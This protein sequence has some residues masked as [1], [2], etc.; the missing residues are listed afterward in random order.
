MSEEEKKQIDNAIPPQEETE[1]E[2]VSLDD[3]EDFDQVDDED[4]DETENEEELD[5]TQNGL[6]SEETDDLESDGLTDEEISSKYEAEVSNIAP[7][8]EP[9]K[10]TNDIE[11]DPNTPQAIAD[12]PEVDNS[13]SRIAASNSGNI[14]IIVVGILFVLGI[15]YNSYKGHK[16]ETAPSDPA[17]IS[18]QENTITPPP[19]SA[20]DDIA[21]PQVPK[22][23]DA[24]KIEIPTIV[25]TPTN[26]QSLTAN[27]APPT[28]PD[29]E[30]LPVPVGPTAVTPAPSKP[31]PSIATIP[32]ATKSL[33]SLV[34]SSKRRD[35]RYKTNMLAFGGKGA[36]N[37]RSSGSAGITFNPSTMSRTSNQVVATYL[38]DL[39]K[40]IAQGKVIDAVLET[41]I[42]TDLPGMVRAIVSRDTYA[43]EG[44]SILIPKGSRLVG[45]Y[46]ASVANGQARVQI[47]WNR[48]IR[49]D[50][51]DIALQSPSIDNIGR[52]GAA[53]VYEGRGLEQ[54]T[55]ALMVSA[56]NYGMAAL[57]D[58]ENQ[59][60]GVKT[61]GSVIIPGSGGTPI[62]NATASTTNNGTTIVTTNPTTQKSQAFSTATSQLSNIAQNLATSYYQVQ[63]RIT[64]D[65]GIKLK[66][67]VQKDLIFPGKAYNSMNILD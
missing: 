26:V 63:P 30:S 9:N 7:I 53:G 14:A 60:Q 47:T 41:A 16:K 8:S 49:P 2:D 13:L 35:A 12:A 27:L 42:S 40:I 23:P 18:Q 10:P 19:A 48:M 54:F 39:T 11:L 22:L 62:N 1:L 21:Q 44:K 28:M 32:S 56:L 38:G 33:P 65:Q 6:D 17:G 58:K 36:P 24:P 15:G 31:I 3:I 45:T 46:S 50:G 25:N 43:E 4:L 52:T 61:G 67:F 66:V 55:S 37:S 34:P 57:Q 59:S 29:V 64:I 51:I 20:S 5:D